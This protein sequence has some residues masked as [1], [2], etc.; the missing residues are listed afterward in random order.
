MMLLCVIVC[1]F[2]VCKL[3]YCIYKLR[4][5]VIYLVCFCVVPFYHFDSN[6][7]STI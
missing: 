4:L 6:F 2:V 3:S 1:I 7:I 5:K